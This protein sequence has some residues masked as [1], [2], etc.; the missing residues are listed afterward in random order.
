MTDASLRRINISYGLLAGQIGTL[1]R[2]FYDRLFEAMPH[3]RPLFRLDIDLQSQHLAAALALIVRNLRDFDLLEE[4]LM[5]LGAGHARVGVRPEH[6]PVLC[7]TMIATL[8]DGSGSAWSAEL[9]ADWTELLARVS[10]IMMNG[11][12]RVVTSPSKS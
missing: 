8:R 6:Y 7:R 4:P 2:S 3:V 10:R 1:T 11:A 12:L 5:D 9:E